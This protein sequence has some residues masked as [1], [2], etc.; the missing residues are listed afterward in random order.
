MYKFGQKYAKSG[1]LTLACVSVLAMGA[2]ATQS[3]SVIDDG[4]E[5]SDPLESTNRAVFKFNEVV[6]DNVIHPA[7]KGYRF[8]V[9]QEIRNSLGNF[10]RNLQ[11]P[12]I[13]ANQLLQG[14]LEGAGN[15]LLRTT[16]NTFAGF[17][18]LFDFAAGGEL[19]DVA[20]RDSGTVSFALSVAE[21]GSSSFPP[22]FFH[23]LVIST[24]LKMKNKQY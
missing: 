9:P 13:F 10:L 19:V 18:G 8:V 23:R 22:A 5:I 4:V 21:A 24:V 11:S 7:V 1:I 3:E 2:C 15:V 14:D 12:V 16:I 20:L 17:G 6:D